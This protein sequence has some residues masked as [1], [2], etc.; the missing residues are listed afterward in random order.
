M[1]WIFLQVI[2]NNRPV[3]GIL[4]QQSLTDAR[5]SENHI[6]RE[7]NP[8]PLDWQ[9]HTWTAKPTRQLITDIYAYIMS[10]LFSKGVGRD[11][12]SSLL[13]TV[14]TH[15]FCFIRIHQLLHVCSPILSAF[16]TSLFQKI[17]NF[18]GISSPWTTSSDSF[19]NLIYRNAGYDSVITQTS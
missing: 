2:Q 15:L 17:T 16:H 1:F 12:Y 10:R 14:L 11:N 8:R 19:D 4:I 5:D 13:V 18:V 6:F 9:S 3:P 7:S